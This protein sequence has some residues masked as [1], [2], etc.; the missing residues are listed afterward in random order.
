MRRPDSG[1]TLLELL[2]TVSLIGLIATV[3]S[4]AVIVTLRQQDNTEGRLNVA[5]AE[6]TVGL[7]MPADL[8]SASDVDTDPQAS[9]CGAVTCG[10]IDLSAGSNVVMLSWIGSGGVQTNVSYHFTP[11]GDGRTYELW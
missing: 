6:Q 7:W 4:T 1:M 10:D 3:L 9:P 8:A 2:I 5:R 11:S